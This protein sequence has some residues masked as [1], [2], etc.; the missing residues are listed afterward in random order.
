MTTTHSPDEVADTVAAIVADRRPEHDRRLV[1]AARITAL[2]NHRG[3]SQVAAAEQIGLS[4]TA[5]CRIENGTAQPNPATA[6]LL[7]EF[8]AVSVEYLL[9]AAA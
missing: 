1:I 4:Q 9:D 3:L 2:R 5:L 7:A 8:Y 6:Q